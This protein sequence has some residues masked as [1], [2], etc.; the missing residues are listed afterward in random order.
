[1]ARGRKGYQKRSKEWCHKPTK[2][3]VE[4]EDGKERIPQVKGKRA[5][6]KDGTICLSGSLRISSLERR[7][8]EFIENIN[9][10]RNITPK[11]ENK[12]QIMAART[13]FT[14]KETCKR[15]KYEVGNITCSFGTLNAIL[16]SAT[17]K[18]S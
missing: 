1:M 6:V 7:S 4:L 13:A 8:L 10:F 15:R 5:S 14:I 18:Q 12:D 16:F 3:F 11:I 9:G 2:D 17:S